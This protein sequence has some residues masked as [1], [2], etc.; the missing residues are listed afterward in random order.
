MGGG[1]SSISDCQRREHKMSLYHVLCDETVVCLP[2]CRAEHRGGP[3][4]PSCNRWGYTAAG[5]PSPGRRRTVRRARC[6]GVYAECTQEPRQGH[7]GERCDLISIFTRSSGCQ[8]R[9]D[10]GAG[11]PQEDQGEAGCLTRVGTSPE[12]GR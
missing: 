1:K 9:A 12:M 2:L 3:N 5:T 11:W 6:G 10:L 7:K 8:G 4:L